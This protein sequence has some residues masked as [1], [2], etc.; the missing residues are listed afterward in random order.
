V[1]GHWPL[2]ARWHCFVRWPCF[3]WALAVRWIWPVAAA[4][5]R[6]NLCVGEKQSNQLLKPSRNQRT[7]FNLLCGHE[8]LT[9]WAMACAAITSNRSA[10]FLFVK[11]TIFSFGRCIHRGM[12]HEPLVKVSWPLSFCPGVGQG[13]LSLLALCARLAVCRIWPVDSARD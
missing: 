8:L 6:T 5:A 11:I 1:F 4:I 10:L 7:Y 9:V 2:A 12:G 13:L 3:G